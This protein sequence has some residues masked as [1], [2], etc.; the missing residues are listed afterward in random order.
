MTEP[1]KHPDAEPATE[2]VAFDPFADDE[3]GTEAVPFDPFADE[4]S[5]G[6]DFSELGE[7]AG[8]LKDLDDLRRGSV[9][10]DT[11]S[12]SRRRALDTFR[13]LR[14][15]RRE[16]RMVADG[17]VELP[18]VEPTQPRTA[19]KDPRPA[20]VEKGIPAPTLHP[21]DIVAGQ[22]EIL[23]VIAHGGLGWIYL[24]EDHNVSERVV[25]L[26]G[27]HSQENPDEAAAA[28]AERE[29]LAD[30]TH[31]GIVKIF[32]FID[33]PRVPSGFIVMEYVGGPSL[34]AQRNAQPDHKL[35]PDVAIGYILEILPALDYLH[36]RGV[37]YND[38]KPD[39]II[40]TEDQVKLIDLG[41]VSGIGAFGYIYGTRGFQAPEVGTEGPTIHSDIYTIGRTLAALVI[42]LPQKDGVYEHGIP[43]PTQE[44]LFRRYISLYRVIARCCDPVASERYNSVQELQAQLLG[45][46][47]E[48]LAIRDGRTFPA[49]QSQFSPQRTTFGTKHLVF[50]TDQLID[51]I[52]RTVEITPQEVV[53]A[54]PTPLINRDDVGA[55]MLQGSSYSE[56]Q[57]T[58]ETLR[59]AMQSDQYQQSLEIPFGVVRSM[60]DLGLTEQAQTWLA[61]MHQ[62][63]DGNW[64][65]YW[66]FGVV[67]TLLGDFHEA[68]RDF[69]RV[70]SFLP[71]ESAPKLAIAAVD[72]LLLQ[73]AGLHEEELLDDALSRASA[74]LRTKLDDIDNAV[75]EDLHDRGLMTEDW[76]LVTNDP[77]MLRFHSMRL[78]S[79]VWVTNPTTV[80]SAFGLA[81]Q[82]MNEGE[83]ELAIAALDKVPNSSRHYRMAQLT[84]ILCL[85]SGDLTESRIRRAARRLDQ[86]PN[87]EPR[88]LQIKVFVL[89]A[90]LTYLR[91]NGM[92]RAD[93]TMPL[94]EYTFSLR[95][96]RRGLA[97]T[98][99]EQARVAPYAQHRFALV[100]MANKVRPATWF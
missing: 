64:R 67:N 13:E 68:Q 15:T 26:K 79:L 38:L 88:F 47:R 29:F 10:E 53:S 32:N 98:L 95:G 3:P 61:S 89:R 18:W 42:D 66:Y 60:L 84:S 40:V 12:R 91:A 83:V 100:D 90:A 63:L 45:V 5:D 20:E 43:T 24:A 35:P 93:S 70:L 92:Q 69:A 41:A 46:L 14:G 74:G 17:M 27:L 72:E 16:N 85:V 31:P 23:G 77:A 34:R 37:V 49:Q 58:L 1:T 94:F 87:T 80:S 97:I 25:V 57:E 73:Q 19:L 51:G 59:Q 78:Y 21:G 75:F 44:P 6:T 96:L 55:G 4:D 50:R 71:G 65:F 28:A 56:P 8:L 82:L 81:R 36:S 54:L 2:A 62:R 52:T 86:I 22:Y 33:D 39:N 9:K 30:I 7:M 76:G 99:R 48:I 11:S